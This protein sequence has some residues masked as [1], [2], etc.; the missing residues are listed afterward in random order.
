M[1]DFIKR[2]YTLPWAARRINRR[3]GPVSRSIH[4]ADAED[5]LLVF[6][7]AGNESIG[8]V[9]K[10]QKLLE[11]DEK[12]VSF[13]SLLL[14]EEDAPDVHLDKGMPRLTREEV[15]LSG[16]I[17]NEN[18]ARQLRKKYDFLVHVD[19]STNEWARLILANSRANCRVGRRFEGFEDLYEIMI[20]IGKSQDRNFLVDQLY[21]Y[22][23]A[24]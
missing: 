11:S 2:Q 18:V 12:N 9:R 16:K 4:Y 22:L 6:S 10:L 7:L 8:P 20:D 13:V 1:I 3:R 21:H 15:S 17:L 14:N 23:K 24:L 5:I 19:L